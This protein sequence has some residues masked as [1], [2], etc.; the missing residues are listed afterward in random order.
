[1]LF[2]SNEFLVF[3]G[4]FLAAYWVAR[5]SLSL[6]NALIVVGSYIFYGWWDPRLILLLLG[7]TL[8][9]FFAA[10]QLGR[11]RS[12]RA[13]KNWVAL[14]AVTNIGLLCVF[15][16]LDFFGESAV[17]LARGLG[18]EARWTPYLFVLPIGISF[19]TFQ[20][21]SYVIDVYRR[22]IPA[23]RNVV[24]F[25]AFVSFFPQLVAGPIE[26]GARLLPQMQRPLTVASRDI[27]PA[28]WLIIWGLFKKVVI[29]DSLAPHVD[30]VFDLTSPGA[31]MTTLGAVAFA[32][33]IYCD[34][35][36]YSDIA[37]GAGRLLG[38]ELMLNFNLPYFATSLRDFWRRWHISLSTWLRDYLYVPLGGN[39]LGRRRTAVNL[40]LTMFLGGLW[41]GAA[42]TFVLWGIWHGAGLALHRWWSASRARVRLPVLAAWALTFLHV[43]YGWI[44]FRAES[45]D[46]AWRFTVALGDFSTPEWWPYYV[47][48]LILLASPL[49]VIQVWQRIT[50]VLDLTETVPPWIL[51]CAQGAMV[52]LIASC[53]QRDP[54]P[55]IYFQF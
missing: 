7:V 44:L 2:N 37:R 41:H 24:E 42:M 35:S 20:A 53:W 54:P 31:L 36:G 22:E 46:Q 6:R 47:R 26:R 28:L 9:D 11:A 45:V 8:F 21:V 23:S 1:V 15:K 12:E 49:V 13:R 51:A 14:V 48:N 5:R 10:L 50:G 33:Q 27:A 40:L 34:F 38:F 4:I 25:M 17:A 3:F 29:A 43:L 39:R 52:F 55:F 30:L 32:L 18:F 16:Y 19:Y